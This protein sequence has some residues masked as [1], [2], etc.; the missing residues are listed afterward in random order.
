MNLCF[1]VCRHPWLFLEQ[2]TFS[3]WQLDGHITSF[4]VLHMS[5][6]TSGR[7]FRKDKTRLSLW[8]FD[9]VQH[10]VAAKLRSVER[11]LGFGGVGLFRQLFGFGKMRFSTFCIAFEHVFHLVV[12]LAFS[13]IG[14]S[15]NW[16]FGFVYFNE[17]TMLL[18]ILSWCAVCFNMWSLLGADEVCWL[19]KVFTRSLLC[20]YC[21]HWAHWVFLVTVLVLCRV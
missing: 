1:C 4:L 13:V 16:S 15:E 20:T 5:G 18:Q 14:F 8:T 17:V 9:K 12:S 3:V 10:T 7:N 19:V 21:S 11:Y 6:W 2:T